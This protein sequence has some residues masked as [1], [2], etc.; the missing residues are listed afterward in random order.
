MSDILGKIDKIFPAKNGIIAQQ[1]AELEQPLLACRKVLTDL[2]RVL[3]KYHDLD[4]DSQAIC[5]LWH[6]CKRL[7]KKL[8]WEPDSVKDIESRLAS[9]LDNLKLIM[10]T[11]SV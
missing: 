1:H 9:N 8:Q 10:G 3:D 11:I 7:W 2:D 4:K 6:K 5:L